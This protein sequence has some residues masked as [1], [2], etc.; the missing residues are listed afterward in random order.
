MSYEPQKQG[1]G[2][3]APATGVTPQTGVMDRRQGDPEAKTT[4]RL[5]NRPWPARAGPKVK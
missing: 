3:I 1:L 2:S 4:A 5:L